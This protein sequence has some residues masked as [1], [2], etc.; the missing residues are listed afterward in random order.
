MPSADARTRVVPVPRRLDPDT[1]SILLGQL[2]PGAQPADFL[3]LR[4]DGGHFCDGM[5]LGWIARTDPADLVAPLGRFTEVLQAIRDFDGI[6]VAVVDGAAQ[7]G[8]LGLLCACDHVVAS[9]GSRFALP[10]GQLG[11]VPG[12]VLPDLLMR[13]RPAE[14]RRMVHT[15]RPWSAREALAAGLVDV[16]APAGGMAAALDRLLTEMRRCRPGVARQLRALMAPDG[17]LPAERS[18]KGAAVLIDM[19]ARPGTRERLH[20][21]DAFLR[22]G[23]PA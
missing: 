19:L 21:I 4:G 9:E 23:A 17:V 6:T 7:G 20:A 12:L 10:E 14:L 22:D 16:V 18:R 15:A 8:G 2:G 5:D 1:T 11:L 3:V 13:L